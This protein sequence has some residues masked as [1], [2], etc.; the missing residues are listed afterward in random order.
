VLE[1]EREILQE[2]F[3]VTAFAVVIACPVFA[4]IRRQYPD[5][6]WNSHGNVWTSPF[7][8]VEAI[9]SGLVFFLASAMITAAPADPLPPSVSGVLQGSLFF[10]AIAVMAI[11]YFGWIRRLDIV[12]LFGLGRLKGWPLVGIAVAWF[13]PAALAGLATKYGFDQFVWRVAGMELENQQLVNALKEGGVGLKLTIFLS[14]V[15]I[16]PLTEEIL[17]RG[18]M[19]ASVKRYT[20]RYFAAV[21]SALAFALLHANLSSFAPL[22]VLGMFF[23]LAYEITGCLAVSILMH[24]FFNAVSVLLILNG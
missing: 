2:L 10:S 20:E 9:F 21:F 4:A 7:G 14:A 13:I 12:E 16:A 24:A 17:F 6:S 19:Y 1:Q 8:V 23:A 5:L 11:A 3:L 18:L 15:V 22:F